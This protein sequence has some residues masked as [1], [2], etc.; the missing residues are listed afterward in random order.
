MTGIATWNWRTSVSECIRGRSRGVALES[1]GIPDPDVDRIG[2]RPGIN[3]NNSSAIVRDTRDQT[4]RVAH[5]RAVRPDR[6]SSRASVGRYSGAR[7]E[8]L[9]SELVLER[10]R[11]E[12]GSEEREAPGRKKITL[13]AATRVTSETGRA[14]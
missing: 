11:G 6:V 7:V 9:M 2:H 12:E 14:E 13:R 4:R 1:R 10:E 5:A 3:Y 8:G